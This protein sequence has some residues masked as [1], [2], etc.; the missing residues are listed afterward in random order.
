M[1]R[2]GSSMGKSASFQRQSNEP[3]LTIV[4]L[5]SLAMDEDH[6]IRQVVIMLHDICQVHR[7]FSAS[8]DQQR[9]G[10]NAGARCDRLLLRS[11]ICDK[12]IRLPVRQEIQ[13]PVGSALILLLDRSHDDFGLIPSSGGSRPRL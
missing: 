2:T 11:S 13:D 5:I 12:N 4:Y 7:G 6:V 8:I 9:S 10:L 1:A 3:R